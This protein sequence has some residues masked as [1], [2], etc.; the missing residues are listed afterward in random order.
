MN[1]RGKRKAG[2]ILGREGISQMIQGFINDY[3]EKPSYKGA[4]K[5]AGKLHVMADSCTF[6]IYWEEKMLDGKYSAENELT[7]IIDA[8]N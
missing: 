2:E 1:I 3:L 5:L 8:N 6:D 7:N 4:V